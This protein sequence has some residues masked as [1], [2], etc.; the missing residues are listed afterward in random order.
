MDQ[1]TLVKSD[2]VAGAQVMEALSRGKMPVT[3]GDWSFVPQ[4]QEWQLIIATPWFDEKGPRTAYRAVVDALRKAKVYENVPMRRVFVR[5]PE[6]PIVKGLEQE[7]KERSKQS[8]EGFIH[9][10]KHGNSGYSVIFAPIAG[11]GGAVAA[12]RFRDIDSVREFLTNEVK[13]KPN[14][15]EESIEEME[16]AGAGSIF[17]VVLTARQIKTLSLG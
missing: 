16:R 3:F 9:I 7:F 2:R 15:I 8:R 14:D 5:S 11:L 1:A 13:A 10:I 6:D 12:R 4:L 17:P